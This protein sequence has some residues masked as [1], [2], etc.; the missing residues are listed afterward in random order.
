MS[1]PSHTPV[2][3]PAL[4]G[5]VDVWWLG[6][7]LSVLVAVLLASVF[8]PDL[9]SGTEQ[10]HLPVPAMV[11]WLWAGVAIGYLAQVGPGRADATLTLSIGVLWATVA[12]A[13]IWTPELV[14]G[15]DPTRVPI[16]ALVTP[17]VGA[18]TPG[19]LCLHAVQHVPRE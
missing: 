8:S 2:R 18:V 17:G 11:N 12:A 3:A 1:A 10:E 7:V 5:R 16:A 14:T 4:S 15:S 9:V 19:F 13:S 6:A